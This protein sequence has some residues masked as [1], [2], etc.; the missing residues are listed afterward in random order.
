MQNGSFKSQLLIKG[1]RARTARLRRC[2]QADVKS[3][4]ESQIEYVYIGS[5][6]TRLGETDWGQDNTDMT[7][8]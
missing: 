8:I 4:A 1:L 5:A 6:F 2:I 3:V 7:L